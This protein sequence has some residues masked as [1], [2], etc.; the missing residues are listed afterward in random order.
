MIY[1]I[2]E[3]PFKHNVFIYANFLSLSST[4]FIS[5]MDHMFETQNMEAGDVSTSNS[6]VV[7]LKR[8]RSSLDICLEDLPPLLELGQIPDSVQ[9]DYN[10]PYHCPSVISIATASSTMMPETIGY[11]LLQVCS[12]AGSCSFRNIYLP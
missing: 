7:N 12:F 8:L 2:S 9:Q 6:G 5:N 10:F 11:V 4:E 1:E 3:I